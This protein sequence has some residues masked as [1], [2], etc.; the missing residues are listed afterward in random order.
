MKPF[1]LFS[2]ALTCA[3]SCSHLADTGP[4][5]TGERS[6]VAETVL[7]SDAEPVRRILMTAP[8]D[9]TTA[10]AYAS[11]L[12]SMRD[13]LMDVSYG[14]LLGTEGLRGY[15]EHAVDWVRESEADRP[16]GLLALVEGRLRDDLAGIREENDA[17]ATSG[18]ALA[19]RIH[20]TLEEARLRY[21]QPARHGDRFACRTFEQEI[22]WVIGQ[23]E[24]QRKKGDR[25]AGRV[26]LLLSP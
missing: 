26:K 17:I 10:D 19:I 18:E 2:I 9:V 25:F 4:A 5:G 1:V 21:G 7:A 20:V 3:C 8:C 12:M 11:E 13:R 15:L 16:R 14:L 22:D 6:A 24:T 23:T